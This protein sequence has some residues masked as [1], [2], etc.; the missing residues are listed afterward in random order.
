MRY[1]TQRVRLFYATFSICL[2]SSFSFSPH[3]CLQEQTTRRH[4]Q[5][6]R[7]FLFTL[8][9][10]SGVLFEKGEW[11]NLDCFVKGRR[12]QGW[13]SQRQEK[14]LWAVVWLRVCFLCFCTLSLTVSTTSQPLCITIAGYVIQYLSQ[15]FSQS[16]DL[17]SFFWPSVYIIHCIKKWYK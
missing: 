3:V 16:F 13:C 12:D 11:E 9:W 7:L 4:L 5:S 2:V 6:L 15:H 1:L 17:M 14:R 10:F 8:T